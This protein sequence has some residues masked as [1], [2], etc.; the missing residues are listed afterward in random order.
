MT[1]TAQKDLKLR[2]LPFFLETPN[3]NAGY[4][5]EIAL[6]RDVYEQPSDGPLSENFESRTKVVIPD[7]SVISDDK[8]KLGENKYVGFT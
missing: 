5:Q 2:Q 1:Q 3:D 8:T 7:L 6:L 4:A